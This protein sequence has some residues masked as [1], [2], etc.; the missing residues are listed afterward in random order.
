[1]ILVT[2]LP[3]IFSGEGIAFID[4]HMRYFKKEIHGRKTCD[5]TSTYMWHLEK[6]KD[7]IAKFSHQFDPYLQQLFG[8][9]R[10]TFTQSGGF[11]G[12]LF[13]FPF[14][15][16]EMLENPSLLSATVYDDEK[17]KT[18]VQSLVA[19][20]NHMLLF[21]NN[22]ENIE[23]YEQHPLSQPKRL[24]K[25]CVAPDYLEVIKARRQEFLENVRRRRSIKC[26]VGDESINTTHPLAIQI[27]DETERKRSETTYW[28]VSKYYAAES[29]CKSVAT[30]TELGYLPLVGVAVKLDT[31]QDKID[32][33]QKDPEGHIFC[34][35]PLP[36]E[37]ESPTGLRVHVNGCFAV[38]QNRR[39]IKWPTADHT[40]PVTDPALIWNQFLVT[41]LLPKT[42]TQLT[43]FLIQLQQKKET[44]VNLLPEALKYELDEMT[45]HSPEYFAR[46]VYAI[47][48]DINIVTHQWRTLVDAF[49]KEMTS[50]RRQFFYTPSQAGRWLHWEDA[51]FHVLTNND[52]ESR[53]LRTILYTDNRNLACVPDYVLK[54]L[55]QKAVRIT[56]YKICESLLNVQSELMLT[57]SNRIELLQYVMANLRLPHDVRYLCGLKLLPL[58]DGTWTEFETNLPNIDKVYVGSK[59]HPSLL[60]AGLERRFLNVEVVPRS[61]KELAKQSNIARINYLFLWHFNVL[62]KTYY[63][64]LNQLLTVAFAHHV[65]ANVLLITAEDFVLR[66]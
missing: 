24:L 4:P 23:V 40:G 38:D 36:L 48:P 2:D 3:S 35:L 19:D 47:I 7:E 65:L 57:D 11:C 61:C 33:C 13:R 29:E 44:A 64:A 17:I 66:F 62:S 27:S 34:F 59:D 41:A 25:V 20:G 12:T 45:K 52:D 6:K 53:L 30:G 37:K 58:A 8:I 22:I 43:T 15:R 31:G 21:L 56:V 54:L 28:L 26:E 49:A 60:L 10:D 9:T 14:R 55:P 18:L 16:R 39:H 63:T 46:L 50:S 32:I 5:P 42:M 1:M 51:T